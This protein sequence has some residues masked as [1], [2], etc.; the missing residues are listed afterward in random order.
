MPLIYC[1]VSECSNT[2][3][4]IIICDK[5]DGVTIKKYCSP[6]KDRNYFTLNSGVVL[7]YSATTHIG[8]LTPNIR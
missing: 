7:L 5:I 6:Q 1:Y 2:F 4:Y 8:R 3:E